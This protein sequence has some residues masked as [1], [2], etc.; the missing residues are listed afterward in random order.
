M[1]IGHSNK[2]ITIRLSKNG[3]NAISTSYDKKLLVWDIKN[4]KIL[5]LIETGQHRPFTIDFL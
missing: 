5:K 1:L 4:L 3:L 2:I